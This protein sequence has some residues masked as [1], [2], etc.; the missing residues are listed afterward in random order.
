MDIYGD[1]EHNN[2]ITLKQC[3][4]GASLCSLLSYALPVNL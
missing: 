3:G 2:R 4:G 1:T